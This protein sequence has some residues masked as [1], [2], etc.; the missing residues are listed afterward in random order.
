MLQQSQLHFS[1]EQIMAVLWSPTCAAAIL[2]LSQENNLC[3]SIPHRVK[4]RTKAVNHLSRHWIL[5]KC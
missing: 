3:N 2:S 4:F 5:E 1:T